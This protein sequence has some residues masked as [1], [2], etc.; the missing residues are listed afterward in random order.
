MRKELQLTFICLCTLVCKV[1]SQKASGAGSLV[2]QPVSDR[3]ICYSVSD[4]GVPKP[5]AFGLDLA[6]LSETKVRRGISFMRRPQVKMIRS[7]F[8][9]TDSLANGELKPKEMG[10]LRQRLNIIHKWLG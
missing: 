8:T 2:A 1:H 4:A 10:I 5:V 7:S 3:T 9:Q 6:W